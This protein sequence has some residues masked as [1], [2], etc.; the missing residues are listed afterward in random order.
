MCLVRFFERRDPEGIDAPGWYAV[1]SDRVYLGP[2]LSAMSVGELVCELIDDA[3]SPDALLNQLLTHLH[4]TRAL[5]R[6]SVP[7]LTRP[8]RTLRESDR[9]PREHR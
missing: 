1:V 5:G 2:T 9:P 3:G 6:W 4:F 8:A 7:R